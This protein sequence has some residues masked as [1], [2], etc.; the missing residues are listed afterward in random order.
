MIVPA[1]QRWTPTGIDLHAGD[2]FA[3][4]AE[5]TIVTNASG[6][7]AS[8]QGVAPD[9]RVAG[10]V[11]IPFEAPQ[12]PCWSLLGRIG[13]KGSV[14]E[15]G[16]RADLVATSSGQL[17]LGINDNFYGDNSG[18]WTAQVTAT[19][20]R[21]IGLRR[22]REHP[23]LRSHRFRHRGVR[24]G[25]RSAQDSSSRPGLSAARLGHPSGG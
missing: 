1:R 21:G 12:L 5:G 10:S 6:S 18:N 13:P 20:H 2:A 24:R 16:N 25:K 14:F 7:T 3:A 17:F 4:T 9:C 22:R 15:I 23:R 8:P 19:E 11:H